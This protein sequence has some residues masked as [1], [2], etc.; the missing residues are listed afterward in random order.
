MLVKEG[1]IDCV[2]EGG[3][4]PADAAVIDLK[5]KWLLPGL[6]DVHLHLGG[7]PELD[8][9]A[10]NHGHHFTWDYAYNVNRLLAHGVT[11]VRSGGDCVPDIIDFRNETENCSICGPRIVAPGRFAQAY[12]GHP[13]YTVYM[14]D[15]EVTENSCVI[16][17]AGDGGERIRP[18]IDRIVDDGADAL[19]IFC[20]DDSKMTYPGDGFHVPRIEDEQ[21]KIIVDIA[22]EKGLRV[23]CHID[24]FDDM[25]RAV[26]AGVDTI[27]HVVN[28]CTD[29]DARI[30]DSLIETIVERG[31]YVVPTLIATHAHEINGMNNGA[32]SVMAAAYDA[33]S[34]MKAAGVKIGA[35]TDAGIPFVDYGDSLHDELAELVQAGSTPLKRSMPLPA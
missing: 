2:L 31:V 6:I 19:K 22:H 34:R 21:M 11:A 14:A 35:G 16:I 7:S 33:V 30:S 17:H 1:A 24:D 25:R 4:A 9:H 12:E 3:E 23:M 32:S 27:E 28:V 8:D 5:G 10:G 18:L 15:P 13:A 20:C 26:N 29:P